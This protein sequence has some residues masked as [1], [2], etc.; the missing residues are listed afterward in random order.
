MGHRS[1]ACALIVVAA[2]GTD[3][4]GPGGGDDDDNPGAG[5]PAELMGITGA[6]NAVR[7]D[8]DVEGMTWNTALAALATGFIADC[9][10]EHSSSNERMGVAGFDYIGENLFSSGGF[11]PTGAQVTDAWAS[12][13]ADYDYDSNSCN[14]V[15]GHYTQIVWRDSTDLGCAVKEC[16]GGYIVSCEYGPGGNFNGQRPY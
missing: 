1:F 10:F 7:A 4:S 2:C 12:E 11:Q 3:P 5:E 9:A 14:G 16:N 13:K 6:H 15:C 8:V